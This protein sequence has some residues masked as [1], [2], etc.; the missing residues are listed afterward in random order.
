MLSGTAVAVLGVGH[1]A[2]GFA[3]FQPGFPKA[4]GV[5][6]LVAGAGLLAAIVVGRWS[7]HRA[8]VTAL[9]STLPLVAW[10]AYAVP[11]EKSS[12]PNLLVLS[13]IIPALAAAGAIRTR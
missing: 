10:F 4:E 8:F 2:F 13:L 12:T 11:V 7:L 6:S 1:I 3:N 9:L 5:A